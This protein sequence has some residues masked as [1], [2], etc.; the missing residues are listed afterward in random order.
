[1]G[2]SDTVVLRKR[3]F[4]F[5]IVCYCVNCLRAI[6]YD[7]AR[8]SSISWETA[9]IELCVLAYGFPRILVLLGVRNK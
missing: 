9:D 7:L 3:F 1:M 5:D 4:D 2:S 8:L 6:K